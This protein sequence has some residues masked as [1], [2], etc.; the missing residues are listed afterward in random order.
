MSLIWTKSERRRYTF[1]IQN[2][3]GCRGLGRI[4]RTRFFVNIAIQIARSRKVWQG[5]Y[6]RKR[7]NYPG[8]RGKSHNVHIITLRK[9]IWNITPLRRDI[10]PQH[11]EINQLKWKTSWAPKCNKELYPIKCGCGEL[12]IG[13]SGCHKVARMN[14]NTKNTSSNITHGRTDTSTTAQHA[15]S[16]NIN[17]IHWTQKC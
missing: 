9:G 12:H 14:K 5:R 11:F 6:T 3:S 2:L 16:S 4:T 17:S 8:S 1:W 10:Y 7:E 15:C 13:E